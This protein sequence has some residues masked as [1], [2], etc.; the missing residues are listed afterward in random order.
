[1]HRIGAYREL[2]AVGQ[3]V[4]NLRHL[5]AP[6]QEKTVCG[7]NGSSA[8]SLIKNQTWKENKKTGVMA[9]GESRNKLSNRHDSST[10]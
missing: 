8:L 5:S 1:M 7:I 9:R 10:W 4:Q 2:K 6:E 3:A